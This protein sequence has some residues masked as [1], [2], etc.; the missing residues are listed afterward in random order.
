M[1][2]VARFSKRYNYIAEDSDGTQWLY[3]AMPVVSGNHWKNSS[4]SIDGTNCR[5][6]FNLGDNWRE[7]LHKINHETGE[8][9]K[10]KMFPD[11]PVDTKVL[12]RDYGDTVWVKKYFKKFN[13]DGNIITFGDGATS[14]SA[15]SFNE[16]TWDEWRLPD[17]SGE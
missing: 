5:V 12:V 15:E 14:W 17:S 3:E 2:A 4:S 9:E 11:L 1:K 16:S 10:V 7:S 8:L 13:M 6:T